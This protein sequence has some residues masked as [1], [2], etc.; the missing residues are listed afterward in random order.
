MP[1]LVDAV[2]PPTAPMAARAWIKELLLL[3]PPPDVA[4]TIHDA[5]EFLAGEP[6]FPRKYAS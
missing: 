5:C 2:L 1:S 4:A 6:V 3:P